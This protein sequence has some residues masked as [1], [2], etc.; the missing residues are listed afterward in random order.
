MAPLTGVRE[1]ATGLDTLAARLALLFVCACSIIDAAIDRYWVS[2]SWL[3][4]S[5]SV[6]AACAAALTLTRAEDRPLTH[7]SAGFVVG[8]AL[9]VGVAVLG[10]VSDPGEV[11]MFNYASYLVALLVV[12]GNPWWGTLGAGAVVMLGI[13]WCVHTG[14]PWTGYPSLL[15]VPVM[16]LTCGWLIRVTLRWIVSAERRHRTEA[17]MARLRDRAARSAADTFERELNLVRD[18]AEP[19]LTRIARGDHLTPQLLAQIS[20]AEAEVRDRI[21]A[22]QLQHPGL[23]AA[24]AQRRAAGESV[25]LVARQGEA[26]PVVSDGVA[27]A[28]VAFLAEQPLGSAVI[29]A[30]GAQGRN[31]VTVVVTA[32]DGAVARAIFSD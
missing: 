17:A 23:S 28:V 19:L 15:G 27:A 20:S 2:D 9:F 18:R 11:W 32:P 21:R 30:S 26:T 6:L 14:Q 16:A 22:P 25:T 8:C 4:P 31:Q 1:G 7:R 10:G 24:I 5:I 29:R 12:R 3:V 13:G